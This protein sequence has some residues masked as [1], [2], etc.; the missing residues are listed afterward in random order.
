MKNFIIFG[1]PGAGKGTQ[2][3][4]L[5]EKYNLIHLSSGAILRK[6]IQDG[7]VSNNTIKYLQAGRLAPEKTIISLMQKAIKKHQKSL[8]LVFDGFPRTLNQAKKLDIILSEK[9][10]TIDRVMEIKINQKEGTKRILE[11]A[12]TSGRTDDNKKTLQTR[13]KIYRQKM[14]PI[15]AYY[16]KQKKLIS[17]DGCRQVKEIFEQLSAEVEKV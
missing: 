17:I 8:G 14:N 10:L 7:L 16:R 1:S 12:K 4:L 3:E 11:R 5:A 2:A 13:F 9:N 6:A 15:K